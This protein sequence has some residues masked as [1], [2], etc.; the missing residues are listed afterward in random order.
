MSNQI[1][2]K[3]SAVPAKVPAITDLA[4]GELGLN[5]YDGKLFLKKNNG[6]DS[7]VELGA[8]IF[9]GDATGSGNGNVALTLAASGVTAGSYGSAT[10]TSTFTVDAKGRLTAASTIAITPSFNSITSK[11]TTLS[12]YG[13]TDAMSSGQ[14]IDG[15]TF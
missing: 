7:I 10:S 11:P 14:S 6:T 3:R 2:I 4:L 12:G 13:I 9:T 15:G 8:N 5:T 1:L